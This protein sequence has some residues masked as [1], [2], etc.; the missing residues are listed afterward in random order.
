MDG[1]W[2]EDEGAPG[3]FT[4]R[5]RLVEWLR[6]GGEIGGVGRGGG[7]LVGDG[8]GDSTTRVARGRETKGEEAVRLA[9]N[10]SSNVWEGGSNCRGVRVGGR[11]LGRSEEASLGTWEGVRP[12][13]MWGGRHARNL[14][15][16]R[17]LPSFVLA[18]DARS[19]S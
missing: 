2:S 5:E 13:L 8:E 16:G 15:G 11:G 3:V 18:L 4:H 19:G 10:A 1:G 9:K 17:R 7:C 6:E 14:L 12:L